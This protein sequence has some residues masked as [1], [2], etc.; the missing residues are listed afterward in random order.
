MKKYRKL[1]SMMLAAAL[2]GGL[3]FVHLPVYAA[4]EADET[5]VIAEEATEDVV[6]E[7]EEEAPAEEETAE[8]E[9]PVE[10]AVE[11]EE[12]IEEEPAGEKIYDDYEYKGEYLWYEPQESMGGATMA[13]AL[14]SMGVSMMDFE[15]Y[16][17]SEIGEFAWNT[18]V[19]Y[20]SYGDDITNEENI[21]YWESVGM[22][23]EYHDEDDPE[24]KWISMVP[25]SYYEDA[26]AEEVPVA[27][28][29]EVPVEEEIVTEE[30]KS[31]EAEIEVPAEEE[32]ETEEEPA[33]EETAEEPV[34]EAEPTESEEAVSSEEVTAEDAEAPA[35]EETGTDIFEEVLAAIEEEITKIEEEIEAEFV[36]EEEKKY[37]VLFVWH[38]NDNPIMMAE[39]YGFAEIAA[40]KEWIVVCPWA[41]NDVIYLEEF[42]RIMDVLR[43]EYPIDETRIYT[44]GFSKGGRVSQ[45]L[46][47]ERPDVITAAVSNGVKAKKLFDQFVEGI[48]G[49]T[50][51]EYEFDYAVP[52]AFYGGEFDHNWPMANETEEEIEAV[53][54]WL[55]IHGHEASQS[56]DLSHNLR[57]F[58]DDMSEK[59]MGLQF[60]QTSTI[61]EDGIDYWVGEFINEE[62]Y[63]DVRFTMAAGAI[64]WP[65][66]YMC[67]HAID[68]LED[69]SKDPETGETI[70][71]GELEDNSAITYM[72]PDGWN[73][74]YD[75]RA[76][77]SVEIDEHTVQFNYLGEAAGSNVATIEFIPD[78][79]PKEIL[80]EKTSGWDPEGILDV[81]VPFDEEGRIM[82]VRILAAEPEE[83][84][85]TTLDESFAAVDLNGGT[86][87]VDV[88][89]HN[90]GDDEIDIPISDA[91][92]ELVDSIRID[93]ER[94]E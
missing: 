72:S 47:F 44:T 42:D 37:P 87:L 33:S 93:E 49:H 23:Y 75:G 56:V 34:E 6:E 85:E 55:T 91:F 36:G 68:F 67:Q 74:T 86:L 27:I 40:E 63:T 71:M 70:Y 82:T 61:H 48:P 66:R 43:E 92:S 19:P 10:E 51:D 21:A 77:E 50:L 57:R 45:R 9:E 7:A 2:F 3:V 39:H 13:D 79:V 25:M 78:S 60:D 16:T 32:M 73:A 24:H 1:I 52:I 89:I 59:K 28:E 69:F 84:A 83:E 22:K 53:N 80:D 18:F 8:T 31:E 65:T 29:E 76:I 54:N 94:T 12:F 20:I 46:A 88:L 62:G 81:D 35:E 30:A 15:A 64:H 5:E 17:K 4:E 90:S 11:E 14:A 26:P 58:S 38:G 41:D